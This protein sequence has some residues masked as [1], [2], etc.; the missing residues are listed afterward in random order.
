MSVGAGT[1][2]HTRWGTAVHGHVDGMTLE[3]VAVLLGRPVPTIRKQL[4]RV[5][6]LSGEE[7]EVR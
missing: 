3:E 7:L 1:P 5:T 6:A 4:E 2:L